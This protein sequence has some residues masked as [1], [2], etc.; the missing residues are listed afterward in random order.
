MKIFLQKH[1]LNILILCSVVFTIYIP[2][3]LANYSSYGLEFSDEGFYLNWIADRHLYKY[4]YTNFGYLYGPLFDIIGHDVEIL[5]RLNVW[6]IY[7]LGAITTFIFLFKYLKNYNLIVLLGISLITSSTSLLIFIDSFLL[8]PNYNTGNFI[9]LFLMLNGIML[10]D[11]PKKIISI[12][13]T[14]FIGISSLIIFLNK[15]TTALLLIPT[16]LLYSYF[17]KNIRFIQL[18]MAGLISISL[19]IIFIFFVDGDILNFANRLLVGYQIILERNA[20]YDINSQFNFK[21]VSWFTFAV[22][23]IFI[24]YKF[25]LKY[26]K[27]FYIT[28]VQVISVIFLSYINILSIKLALF[29]FPAYAGLCFLVFKNIEKENIELNYELSILVLLLFFPIIYGYGTNGPVWFKVLDVLFFVLLANILLIITL[30][31]HINLTSNILVVTLFFGFYSFNALDEKSKNPY[32]QPLYSDMNTQ[33]KIGKGILKIDKTFSKYITDTRY[34]FKKHEFP[35]D[36]FLIDFTGRI[37]A[38]SFALNANLLGGPWLNGGYKGG[39]KSAIFAL[40]KLDCDLLHS[41]WIILEP[42]GP[43][44]LKFSEGKQINLYKKDY[45][46]IGK[47]SVPRLVTGHPNIGTQYIYKP[48]INKKK[49]Y[50]NK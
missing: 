48:R 14:F 8:T 2:V 5:R 19:L 24:T 30:T 7:I 50:C 10:A 4:S 22:F 32:R 1:F 17:S 28:F 47:V 6:S 49:L 39:T 37:P 34:V 12:T 35:I 18:I 27:I 23:L 31:K 20:G 9:G 16:L 44:E 26:R 33:I 3:Y 29:Y 15:P 45:K 41:A 46:F 43:R 21:N 36:G 11:Q 13:G 42:G 38:M 40:S 25:R